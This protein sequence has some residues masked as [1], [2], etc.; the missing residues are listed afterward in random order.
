MAYQIQQWM[1][2]TNDYCI[3]RL[4]FEMYTCIYNEARL[5][6]GI[7]DTEYSAQPLV[8]AQEIVYILLS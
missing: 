4:S 2:L 7:P 6:A 1:L 3:V 8:K 5:Y